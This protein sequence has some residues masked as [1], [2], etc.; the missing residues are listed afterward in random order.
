MPTGV[1][2]GIGMDGHE[3]TNLVRGNKTKLAVGMCFSNE[4][5]IAIPGEFGVRIEDCFH[6][7]EAG[8][9]FFTTPSPSMERAIA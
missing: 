6:M 9:K 7:T 1:R 3:W 5:M 4:P 2:C 8:P